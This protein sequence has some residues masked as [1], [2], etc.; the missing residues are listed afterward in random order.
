MAGSD[1]LHDLGRFVDAQA[2]NHDAAL[3]ELRAGR[4]RTHW[5]WYVLPQLRGLGTSPMAWRYGIAGLAEARAYLAHP[6]LGPRLLDCVEALNAL[7]G[8]DPVAI[9]GSVDALKLHSCLT[10][11]ARAAADDASAR[12]FRA[13]LGKYYAGAE[14]EATLQRLALALPPADPPAA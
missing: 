5:M 12:P 9:L 11:Y 14:D 7:P 1:D 4:K 8:D 3:A 2:A 13:A 6:L 10:L